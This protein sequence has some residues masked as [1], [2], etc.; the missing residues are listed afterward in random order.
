MKKSI[1]L[2]TIVFL[3]LG[4]ACQAVPEPQIAYDPAAL[5]FSGEQAFALE[6]EYVNLFPDRQN[7]KPNNR[8][9]VEWFVQ[10]LST[11]GWDCQV[12]EWEVISY[13]QPVKLNN[14]VCRLPGKSDRE[15]LVVAHQDIAVTTSQGAD[16]DAAGVAILAHLAEIFAEEG[17][18]A[19]TLVF[20][21][22]DGEEL[23][24]AGTGRYMWTHPDPSKIIAGFS[25][26][27]LGRPYY[28]GMKIEMIGQYHGYTPIWLPLTV[29]QLPALPT[30]GSW[31]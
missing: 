18:P 22:T 5:R 7:G 23:G 19:Y 14:G 31:V 27:N 2:I 8:L 6:T 29:R 26:D 17:Q 28:D 1:Y 25:L 16:N 13:S 30:C 10:R 12:D 21:S 24:M 4:T 9:A 20:V 11:L 3:I 15:I